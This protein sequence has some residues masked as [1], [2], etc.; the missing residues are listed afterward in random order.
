MGIL[1]S[2]MI[3]IEDSGLLADIRNQPASLERVLD[4]Y[5]A[6]GAPSLV[7]AAHLIQDASRVQITGMGASLYAA[8]G[9]ECALSA[10]GVNSTLRETAEV[11]HYQESIPR[12]TL[13]VLISRS[14]ETVEI[15]K[16]AQKAKEQGSRLLA[17]TNN[18]A[19]SLIQFADLVL[20]MPSHPDGEMAIQSYTAAV[21]TLDL[22]ASSV[23]GDLEENVVVLKPLLKG[24]RTF[25]ARVIADAPRWDRFFDPSLPL[26]FLGRGSSFGS[27][28]EGAMLWN[29]TAKQPAM[30]MTAGNFRHGHIEVVDHRFRAVLFAPEGKTAELNLGLADAIARFGGKVLVIGSMVTESG[31]TLGI[32][33]P[34]VPESWAPL[35]EILP[36]QIAAARL[37]AMKGLPVGSLRY[38]Q[39]ITRDEIEF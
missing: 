37:A 5:S 4:Y 38:A 15:V 9:L 2:G 32:E 11:L 20:A 19:S 1:T 12:N 26:H 3:Q 33:T 39:P 14:G 29:E 17:V 8:V 7:R 13:V 16:F 24:L 22:V 10:L 30:A 6:E 34:R 35:L 23:R 25:L 31:T 18:P 28:C 36:I 21:L 27:A